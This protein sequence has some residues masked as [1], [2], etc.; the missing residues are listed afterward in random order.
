MKKVLDNLYMSM[1]N[2][3][4]SHSP[5]TYILHLKLSGPKEAYE[6]IGRRKT[7]NLEV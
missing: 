6:L 1:D 2:A 5:I 7:E 4:V 3:L